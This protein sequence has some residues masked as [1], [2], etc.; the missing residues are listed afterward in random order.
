M[1]FWRIT[2]L[3][4]NET[5]KEFKIAFTQYQENVSRSPEQNISLGHEVALEESKSLHFCFSKL[6]GLLALT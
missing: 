1:G 3:L 6:P 4:R 5:A 2:V